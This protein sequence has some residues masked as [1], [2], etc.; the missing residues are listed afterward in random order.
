M[1]RL[2]EGALARLEGDKA[3]YA[4]LLEALRRG[5]ARVS[6]A[7]QEGILLYE[8]DCGAWMM[9]AADRQTA[10][11]LLAQVPADCDLFVGHEMFY[12][13][14]AE[15]KLGFPAQQLCYSALYPGTQ[16]LEIPPFGGEIR[17]LGPEWSTWLAEHYENGF[18]GAAY[19]EGAIRR[20]VLGLFLDGEP[21]GFVGVH[22]EGSIGMLEVLP[23][24]RRRGL[25]EVLQRSAVNLA[26]EQGRLPFGQ[27]F[28]KNAASLALQRRV[29]MALS[30][31]MMFWAFP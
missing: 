17:Q 18:G 1:S 23:P 19:M 22:E 12:R 3:L 4:N 31:T 29:G 2:G 27:V 7:G 21:A 15:E 14:A 25:G 24:F 11:R 20:G 16:P 6:W 26:L 13:A 8:A 28:A 10:D 5:S 30:Q 9:S